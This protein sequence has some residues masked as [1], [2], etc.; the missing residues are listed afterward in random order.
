[1]CSSPP[2]PRPPC[3]RTT[4]SGVDTFSISSYSD[5][6]DPYDSLYGQG[7]ISNLTITLPPPPIQNLTLAQSNNLWQARVH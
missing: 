7:T 3:P 6:G 1:M 4:T 2:S 5:I